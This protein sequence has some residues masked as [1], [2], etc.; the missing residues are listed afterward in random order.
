MRANQ[1]PLQWLYPR[2]NNQICFTLNVCED[3]RACAFLCFWDCN[4]SVQLLAVE[5]TYS[6]LRSSAWSWVSYDWKNDWLKHVPCHIP[7]WFGGL[8]HG[9]F[10]Y[11][12]ILLFTVKFSNCLIAFICE[13]CGFAEWLFMY[14]N[15]SLKTGE[16]NILADATWACKLQVLLTGL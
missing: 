4:S 11:F 16:N 2:K 5:V 13:K 12:Q 14:S 9:T 10:Q 8:V 3:A 6:W 7:L 15:I 1:G